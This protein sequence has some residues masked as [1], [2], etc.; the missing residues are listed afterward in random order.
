MCSASLTLFESLALCTVGLGTILLLIEGCAYLFAR[1]EK[2]MLLY[3]LEMDDH[4]P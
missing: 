2:G 1:H 3:A 4:A